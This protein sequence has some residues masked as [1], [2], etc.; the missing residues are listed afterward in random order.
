MDASLSRHLAWSRANEACAESITLMSACAT[1]R[2]YYDRLPTPLYFIYR[3]SVEQ[4]DYAFGILLKCIDRFL[5]VTEDMPDV[6]FGARDALFAIGCADFYLTGH[7]KAIGTAHT[8]PHWRAYYRLVYYLLRW[9]LGLQNPKVAIALQKKLWVQMSHFGIPDAE[10][11]LLKYMKEIC[12]FEQ[13]R[14]E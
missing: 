1:A 11:A 3:L 13:W 4:P 6:L 14:M 2:E 8:N 10:Q 5:P 7:M 12:P 9:R